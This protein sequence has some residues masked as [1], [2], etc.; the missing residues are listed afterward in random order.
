[1]RP[2]IAAIACIYLTFALLEFFRTGFF[3]KPEQTPADGVVEAVST[4]TTLGV[5]Q[6]V[7]AACA[8]T[9]MGRLAPEAAG[10]LS[11]LPLIAAFGL[12]FV[13]DD[14]LN[15]LYH[16]AAHTVPG[17]YDLHR[18][19]HDARYM[20]VRVVF[21]NNIFYYM[22]APHLWASGVLI[23]LGLGWVY[24][25]YLVIRLVVSIS[26]HSDVC[27]DAP[28]YDKPWLSPI[29]WLVE[30]IIVT[31]AVHH[32]HHGRH[33]AD[34]VTH[35][36]G[37]YGNTLI[38]WDLLFGTARITRRFPDAYGV[39]D[40]PPTTAGEQLLWPLVRAKHATPETRATGLVAE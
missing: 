36:K 13:F 25:L 1:M 21:R 9:A 38:I 27:W 7:I 26:S 8:A 12:F 29:L 14:F 30:R 37:N 40:L 10:V 22:L 33:A 15:Y 18:A 32:A 23:Y 34:G 16:R 3:R 31:P 5:T 4:F 19:H 17:L 6:P 11:E 35:Y 2:E 20:G 28:L 39:E 24:A